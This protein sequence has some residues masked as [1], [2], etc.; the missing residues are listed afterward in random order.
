MSAPDFIADEMPRKVYHVLH[1]T[2]HDYQYSVTLSQ[3]FMHLTP[4][5]FNFQ[6]TLAHQIEIEP[7]PDDGF[8]RIDYFGNP[9]KGMTLTTP[10]QTLVVR[11]SSTV[12]LSPRPDLKTIMNSMAWEAMRD[13][14]RGVAGVPSLESAQ[15]LF[16][17]PHVVCN[18]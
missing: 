14:L 8:D 15:F 18:A 4:R 7:A 9:T 12:E 13:S 16:E 3:Q 1:E 17:S 2:R 6:E 11:A 10:H 5:S